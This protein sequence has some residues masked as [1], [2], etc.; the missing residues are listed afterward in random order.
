MVASGT[1]RRSA[2]ARRSRA[3]V[4]ELPP[5]PT[6]LPVRGRITS[7]FSH[8]LR[9]CASGCPVLVR[10]GRCPLQQTNSVP[11][12]PARWW[13]IICRASGGGNELQ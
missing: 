3:V 13:V 5:R 9:C 7:A 6:E 8:R 2:P 11:L 4:R 1:A 10:T 12:R